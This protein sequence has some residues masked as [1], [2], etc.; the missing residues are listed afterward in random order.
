MKAQ[1]IRRTFLEW[2][3]ARDHRIVPSSPLVPRS[4]PTL[5]FANAGMVQFKNVFTGAEVRDYK[6]AVSS[7]RCLRVSGKHN[8]LEEV[9]RTP[10]HH[11]LFEM[12]GNFS[13]GDYFKPEAIA[14]AWELLT[15]SGGF[16]LDADR[17]WVTVFEEDDE[18]RQIWIDQM[19][20][21]A[22]RVQ[23]L[24][25]KDNFW[26]MGPTGPCGPC[27][28]IHWD[29]GPGISD[30]TRGPAGEGDRYVEIWNLVFMQ[31]EQLASGERLDLPRPSID[32]GMGL[33]RLA[34]IKQGVYNNYDADLFQGIIRAATERAGVTYGADLKTDTA[35]RVIAD[36]SRAA[37]FLVAD[38]ITPSN[39][40]RGYVLRRL[41]R[42]AARFGVVLGLEDTFL[43]QT[44]SAVIEEMGAAYP[45]LVERKQTILDTIRMEEEL[46]G[47]TRSNGLVYLDRVINRVQDQNGEQ[48]SGEDAFHLHGSL[49]FPLD[50]T[51]LIA[52]ERGLSVDEEGFHVLLEAERERGREGGINTGE[53][54]IDGR[55]FALADRVGATTFTGYGADSGSSE[56]LAIMRDG[57]PLD[58]L[59]AGGAASLV[60]RES[61]FYA[62][63]GGQVGD[64]GSIRGGDAEF[65]V[66][67]VVKGPG[68]VFLHQGALKQGALAVGDAAA[69]TVDAGR[70]DLTRLNHTAT[71]LLHAALKETLG[72]HVVQKG[73]LVT[74]DRL[75]F[76]FAHPNP[77]QVDE[78]EAIEARVGA[79][80]LKNI[81]VDTQEKT[82]DEARAAGAVALFGE[83]YGDRVRVVSVG[84]AS[85]ELCG[86]TH[87]RRSGDIG[88]FVI[89]SQE[90]VAAG[91]RRIEALTGP[92]AAAYQRD[93]ARSAKVAAGKLRTS[94]AGLGDA[95]DR[96]QADRKRLQRELEAL[97]QELAQATAGDLTANVREVDGVKVL[98][99]EISGDMKTLLGEVDRL[100]DQLG[101]GLV[102]LASRD[103]GRVTLV[104]GATRDI[105]GGS[106]HAGNIVKAIAPMVGA[107]GGGRPELARAGGG[108]NP[109]GLPGALEAVYGMVSGA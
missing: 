51:R 69:L 71:H 24:G 105:A 7:Q 6:R 67:Q 81:A 1:D 27:S 63:S 55:L 37:T 33:E 54:A 17:L 5:F 103:N 13:F 57:E 21:P 94:V 20:V 26:S 35:L 96:I 90:G 53:D 16:N 100:R 91:I 62:E 8:D 22:S 88:P 65:E 38:G 4:D 73:S 32:T 68:G 41:L 25:A 89:T 14:F 84:A 76:D 44:A 82:L 45:E 15:S 85:V 9:G 46:F 108:K 92:A 83:K 58:A 102:A 50:L 80:V 34:A 52:G 29:H 66:S 79:E 31:Y 104:V 59:A 28:E 87:A 64:T 86:G 72:A 10:R 98:A 11:T 93:Q 74:P 106:V 101:S 61:P 77:L 2:F 56:I 78:L 49:G 23:R 75:R 97:R 95:I 48:V 99:A 18:A 39:M 107:R 19:G 42:R 30:D 70:R 43:F 12:L 109:D 36:H 40:D 60:V 47:R 3:A